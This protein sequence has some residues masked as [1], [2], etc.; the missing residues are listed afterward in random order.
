MSSSRE[1]GGDGDADG[2]DKCEMGSIV[3][4]GVVEAS[5]IDELSTGC[6]L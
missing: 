2:Y 4:Y 1:I 3:R 5:C 6:S